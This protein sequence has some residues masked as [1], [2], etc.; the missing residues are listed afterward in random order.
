MP[1]AGVRI[2]PGLAAFTRIPR[3]SS[4]AVSTRNQGPVRHVGS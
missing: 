3:G 4:S 1:M 2:K